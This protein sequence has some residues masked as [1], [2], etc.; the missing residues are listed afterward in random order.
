MIGHIFDIDVLLKIDSRPWIVNKFKPNEP[1]LKISKADYNLFK[2]GVYKN[3]GNKIEYND[4]TYWLPTDLY[5]KLRVI[6]KNQKIGMNDLAISLQEFLNQEIVE[7][8]NYQINYDII[9]HL[10]NKNEDI[11]LICSN[12]TE[13]T[14]KI[15]VD[16]LIEKLKEEGIGIK[17]FYYIN[18]TFYNVSTDEIVYKK[19]KICLQHLVGYEIE[20]DKFVD[21]EITKYSKLY[22]YDDDF[23]TLKMADEINS[24]LKYILSKTPTGLKEVIRQNVKDDKAEFFV[25]KITNNKFNKFTTSDVKLSLSNIIKFENFKWEK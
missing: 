19:S 9:S 21:K 24:F 14:F 7:N 17:K 1:L 3:Q 8:T 16:K 11:Y 18:D 23:D 2:N 25:N 13:R 5:N 10:K 6:A 20:N 4:K 15:L 12:N 22:F